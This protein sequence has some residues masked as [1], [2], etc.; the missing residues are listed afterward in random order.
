MN[1]ESNHFL[2][3]GWKFPVSFVKS[4]DTPGTYRSGRVL[5][6]QDE[7]DIR[8][9]LIILFGTELTERPVRKDY[10]TRISDMV[11]EPI[12]L[13]FCTLMEDMLRTAILKF[14]PRIVV[15]N[16]T[17]SEDQLLEGQVLVNI[18]Y[19]IIATNTRSNLV[20]P[21][22]LKE[23]TEIVAPEYELNGR[24]LPT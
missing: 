11:F 10:G 15:E 13:T 5:M 8:E 24:N 12:T 23:A 21:I 20:Y 14:E 18:V 22:Y 4:P 6:V 17:C 2:G 9:S 7:E 16:L 1:D 19:T 3:T